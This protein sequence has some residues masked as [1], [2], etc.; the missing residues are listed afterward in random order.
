MRV[1][2]LSLLLDLVVRY[3][4]FQTAAPLVSV[5]APGENIFSTLPRNCGLFG[6]FCQDEYGFDSG[7][8]MAAPHV[9]GLAALVLSEHSAFSAAQVKQCIVSAARRSRDIRIRTAL[10]HHQCA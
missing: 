9:A 1:V 4:H 2:R 5:A 8:S 3:R 6:L 10:P 7:T